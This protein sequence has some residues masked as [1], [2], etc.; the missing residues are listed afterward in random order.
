M[1]CVE[2]G[3]ARGVPVNASCVMAV[4]WRRKKGDFRVNRVMIGSFPVQTVTCACGYACVTKIVSECIYQSEWL[5]SQPKWGQTAVHSDY[6]WLPGTVTRKFPWCGSGMDIL[7]IGRD[8]YSIP[9]IWW[10]WRNAVMSTVRQPAVKYRL[11]EVP[12]LPESRKR[13]LSEELIPS[14]SSYLHQW[15]WRKKHVMDSQKQLSRHRQR[16]SRKKQILS[17]NLAAD[18]RRGLKNETPNQDWQI[19]GFLHTNR[20]HLVSPGDNLESRSQS[21]EASR[22]HGTI[23]GGGCIRPY[24]EDEDDVICHTCTRVHITHQLTTLMLHAAFITKGYTNWKDATRKKAGFS[25]HERS[26]CHREAVERS[27]TLHPTTKDAGEHI[28]S[29]REEDKANNRKA[30]MNMLSN[31]RFLCRRGMPL[32]GD[33]DGNNS[34]FTQI[35]HLRT[36]DKSAL[37]TWLVKKSNKFTSRQMKN[38]MLTVMALEVLTDVA[39]SLHSS[40]FYSIMANETTDS[41]NRE[42]VVI[43]LRWLDNSLNASEKCIRLQQVDII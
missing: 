9:T 8:I 21:S 3:E 37:S 26:Q 32:R 31:T 28:S 36:K 40:P 5:T 7:T 17:P 29:A 6:A 42:K 20:G 22:S 30:I 24:V 39:A 18:H 1:F 19:L 12:L 33:G 41:H 25:Q 15:L 2:R 11:L 16:D 38:K 34:N 10:Q 4:K 14:G 23:A 43:C 35:V 27:I 13:K